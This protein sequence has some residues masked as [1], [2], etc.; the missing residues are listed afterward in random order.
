MEEV[1]EAKAKFFQAASTTL[2]RA[3]VGGGGIV[4]DP[5][6]KENGK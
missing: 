2:A 6:A 5:A 4:S 1:I 3:S